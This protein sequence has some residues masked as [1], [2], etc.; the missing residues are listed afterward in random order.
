MKTPSSLIRWVGFISVLTF[1]AGT[2]EIR[3][4]SGS[5]D[6]TFNATAITGEIG[7]S[8]AAQSDGK[9][10]A[11]GTFGV[12]RFLRDGSIDS[13]FQGIP[14]GTSPYTGPGTGV[15]EVIVQPDG[16]IL[17]AGTFTNAAGS[18]LPGIFRL[19]S[20]GTLDSSFNLSANALPAGRILLQPD[21]KIIATG[22]YL[23]TMSGEYGGLIRLLPDGSLDPSFDARAIVARA[24][25]ALAPDGKIYFV[26]DQIS[27]ANADGS[28]DVTF[29]VEVGPSYPSTLTVQP[30]GKLLVGEYVEAFYMR[31]LLPDGSED[32]EWTKPQITGGDAVVQS[33]LLQPDG[34]IVV[35][36][37]N[38]YDATI[39]RLNPDG[40][41]D[42]TFDSRG[43]LYSYQVNDMA[44]AP[45]GRILVAG[46]RLDRPL[47]TA[48]PGVWRLN[49]DPSLQPKLEIEVTMDA[50]VVL[51]LLGHVGARYRLEYREE[52][53]GTGAWVPLT[54]LTLSSP[55]A[56]FQDDGWKSSMA[57]FYRC[58]QAQ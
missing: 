8:V 3:A 24:P 57:R 37:N 33:I 6:E 43:D 17:V 49:N 36:G 22:N 39:G 34:K 4:Q 44:L 55:V 56:T 50:G 15:G 28:L 40:T 32:P 11:V 26:G 2:F 7:F 45:D 38:V 53:P 19:N 20:D 13:S 25:I 52:L 14:P 48:A 10:I 51:R 46:Y 16:R 9:V 21:G 31:R 41:A 29:A 1:S 58:V 54:T 18:S 12:N 47:I 5:L 23:D 30:D 42:P 27:R 35:G